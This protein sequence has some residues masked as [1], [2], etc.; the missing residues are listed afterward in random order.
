MSKSALPSPE[1]M[2][3]PGKKLENGQMGDLKTEITRS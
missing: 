1:A 2:T 3:R